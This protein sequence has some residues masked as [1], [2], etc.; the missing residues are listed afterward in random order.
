MMFCSGLETRPGCIPPLRRSVMEDR[1][2]EGTG[3]DIRCGWSS[4]GDVGR[5][6]R[7]GAVGG[8]GEAEESCAGACSGVACGMP[9]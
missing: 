6:Y 3:V 1:E 8:D 7:C 5:G 4:G 2:R 9:C